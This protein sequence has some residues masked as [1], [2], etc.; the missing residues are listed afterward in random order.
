MQFRRDE[1]FFL[2]VFTVNL[3][4]TLTALFFVLIWLVLRE[5]A[6]LGSSLVPPLTVGAL[7]ATVLPVVLYPLATLVWSALDLSSD[8][9][10]VDEIA[11]AVDAIDP[12]E[13]AVVGEYPAPELPRE[14]EGP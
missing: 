8:P 2:G 5:A 10:D 13:A 3:V 1:A 9:L 11:A 6:E 12:F 7:C 14:S 4:V